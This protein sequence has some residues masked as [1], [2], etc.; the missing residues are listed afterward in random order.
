[1]SGSVKAALLMLL[2]FRL[3]LTDFF[4]LSAALV[5]GRLFVYFPV[6]KLPRCSDICSILFMRAA[7]DGC[8]SAM[9]AVLSPAMI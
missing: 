8:P 2:I 4:Y 1:M 7:A 9:L 3:I 5:A 6:G